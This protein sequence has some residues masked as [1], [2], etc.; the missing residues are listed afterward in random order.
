MKVQDVDGKKLEVWSPQEVADAMKKHEIILFDVRTPQEYLNTH[1]RGV[2]MA[3]MS[4]VDLKFFPVNPKQKV[5]FHCGSGI[6]SEMVSKRYLEA[7]HSEIAHM[8]G[9]M[10]AWIEAKLP[11]MQIDPASGDMVKVNT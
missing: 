1:I 4:E 8:E 11:Y 10:S 7:G 2:F 3:P 5:V 6:R 9:G